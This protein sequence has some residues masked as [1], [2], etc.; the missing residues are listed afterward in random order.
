MNPAAGW[1]LALALLAQ[2]VS[3]TGVRL[4]AS[5]GRLERQDAWKVM[6]TLTE[7]GGHLPRGLERDAGD[8]ESLG[9][10]PMHGS[11]DA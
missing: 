6:A 2:A 1:Q 5:D 9:G 10:G 7:L 4:Q 11:P 8:L 3:H